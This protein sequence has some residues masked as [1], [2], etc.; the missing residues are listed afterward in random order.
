MWFYWAAGCMG[1]SDCHWVSRLSYPSLWNSC[2][3]T[4]LDMPGWREATE[5]IRLA[6]EAT[7]GY[8][9]DLK[10]LGAWDTMWGHK[11]KDITTRMMERNRRLAVK[12]PSQV[13]YL[14][15]SEVLRSLRHNMRAQSQGHHTRND[16]EKRE[17][18]GI[19]SS[20]HEQQY[21]KRTIQT[22]Q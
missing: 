8:S 15:R 4:A 16:G 14:R 12:E 18:E 17:R 2:G 22:K 5:Q 9:E 20:T 19:I 3:C 10:C 1:T 21:T 13:A 11:T 7:I 6:G